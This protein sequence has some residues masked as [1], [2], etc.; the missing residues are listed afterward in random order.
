MAHGSWPKN[1]GVCMKKS[2]VVMAAVIVLVIVAGFM[3]TRSNNVSSVP[4]GTGEVQKVTLGLKN[5]NYDPQVITVKANQPVE[6]TLDS[7]VMGCLRSFTVPAFGVS[8]YSR[9]PSQTITF[10]PNKAGTYKFA[11]SMGMGYGTLVVE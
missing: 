8:Q 1:R 6:I 9:D 7:S 2:V 3:L 5:Y 4:Q 10:T 11:C